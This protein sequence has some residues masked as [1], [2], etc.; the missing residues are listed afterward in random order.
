MKDVR[1]EG[2]EDRER[3]KNAI[4]IKKKGKG[5]YENRELLRVE[6]TIKEGEKKVL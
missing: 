6:H 5:R 3:K 4:R 1:E 2:T